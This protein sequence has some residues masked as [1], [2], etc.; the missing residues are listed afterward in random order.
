[1]KKLDYKKKYLEAIINYLIFKKKINSSCKNYLSKLRKKN[2]AINITILIIKLVNKPNMKYI[3]P[4]KF[5]KKKYN[6]QTK[7]WDNK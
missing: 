5:T 4:I 3:K 1:M 6:H 7:N 2:F